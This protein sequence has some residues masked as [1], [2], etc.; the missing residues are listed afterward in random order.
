V[1]Q[2][3]RETVEQVLAATDIV[4]VIGQYLPLRRAGTGFLALCPFHHEKTPSF[5]INPARQF[6]HCFGCKKSGDAIA[7]VREYEGLPF[8]DAVRKLAERAGIAVV[9]QARDPKEEADRRRRGQLL[10]L[11]RKLTAYYHQ[12]L[13]EAPEARHARDYLEGRGFTRETAEKWKIGWAPP[14]PMFVAWA[15]AE[16]LRGR[17]L[18]DAGIIKPGQRGAYFYFRDRLMF[19][20][21]NDYGDVIGFSGRQLDETQKE[22]KYVNSPETRLFKKS[23]VLFGLDKARKGIMDEK[24][25]L[26]CEGQLDAIACHEH[27][28]VH[29]IA[30][31][32]T[33][34]PKQH[35]RTLRRYTK[36]A[37]LCYDS[38]TAGN[39]AVESAFLILAADGIAVKVVS[40]PPGEDPDS[41]IKKNGVEAFRERLAAAGTFFDFRL[42]LAGDLSDPLRR[43]TFIEESAAR[44]AVIHDDVSR[45]SL[46]QHLATRLRI[47]APELQG[48]VTR[49]RRAA[50]KA[51]RR[52]TGED[53]ESAAPPA[54]EATPLDRRIGSLCS[55]ALHSVEAREWLAE[56]FETLHE[57]KRHLDGI[58]ILGKI[59]AERPDPSSPAAI[60]LFRAS[61]PEGDR[62]ALLEEPS[63]AESLPG[64]PVASAAQILA[65]ASALALE[66]E[67]SRIKAAL[68][69]PLLPADEAAR[70]LLRM[71]EIGELQSSMPNRALTNDRFAPRRRPEPR[72]PWKRG[73]F[74]DERKS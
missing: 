22:G 4:D 51:P 2:I 36:T 69:D 68:A 24:A 61:L 34:F 26:I 41:F 38:D 28:I 10:D 65:D 67:D 27:G 7:F 33:A 20:I 25:V 29:A 70:L 40:M 45:E 5:N 44:L 50:R 56:Q 73:D 42:R 71:K 53:E 49:A 13:L 17:D 43:S 21:A 64:D 66:K 18:A 3:P 15:K 59:L 37:I 6:F 74:G 35:A 9:E 8:S 19:P 62:L 39:K 72:K 16:G 46:I 47:G 60:N 14:K 31:L 48:A 52:R 54:A 23:N 1:P 63:F 32:G 30:P 55:L 57:L 12:L 11:H 58:G